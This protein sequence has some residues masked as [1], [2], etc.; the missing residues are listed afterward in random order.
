M[1]VKGAA[2]ASLILGILSIFF[3]VI[4]LILGVMGVIY[5]RKVVKNP[6][7]EGQHA[8]MAKGGMI[9]SIIGI[10]LQLFIILSLIFGT[11]LFWNF[12]SFI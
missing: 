1:N 9:C 7:T 4:G 11:L 5:G 10:S 12:T 6:E 2:L 8:G 3:P